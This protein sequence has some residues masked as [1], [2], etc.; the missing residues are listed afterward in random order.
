M[1][2]DNAVA[3]AKMLNAQ[4]YPVNLPSL[5]IR[6]AADVAESTLYQYLSIFNFMG[7]G[8]VVQASAST[9]IT[10]A[11][12][13][14]TIAR[15]FTST[16]RRPSASMSSGGK[17]VQLAAT[18]AGARQAMPLHLQVPADAA[19]EWDSGCRSRRG[20]T[21]TIASTYHVRCGRSLRQFRIRSRA[22]E[23]RPAHRHSRHLLP[24]AAPSTVTSY[25]PA[26]R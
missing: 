7:G 4:K 19:I 1:G 16:S 12:I 11:S 9:A 8:S 15:S 25:A 20:D 14:R 26:G 17:I 2:G 24:M 10:P 21:K 22:A 5:T 23:R 3:F 6:P 18:P 13:S